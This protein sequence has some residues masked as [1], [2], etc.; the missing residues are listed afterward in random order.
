MINTLDPGQW[1]DTWKKW[2]DTLSVMPLIEYPNSTPN[3]LKY[4]HFKNCS[5]GLCGIYEWFI[6]DYNKIILL[7]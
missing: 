4:L 2:V 1:R 6:I 3:L 7:V 5:H